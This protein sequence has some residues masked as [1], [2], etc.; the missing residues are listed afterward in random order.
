MEKSTHDEHRFKEDVVKQEE[1]VE[2]DNKVKTEKSIP[3]VKKKVK[4]EDDR[5]STCPGT[6]LVKRERERSTIVS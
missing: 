2:L 5:K 1:K 4:I 3:K 6:L